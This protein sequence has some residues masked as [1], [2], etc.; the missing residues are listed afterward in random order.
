MASALEH[1]LA[2]LLLPDS[3]AIHTA[4]AAFYELAKQPGMHGCVPEL[5][6]IMQTNPQTEVR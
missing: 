3:H 6:R 5:V 4:T 1:I 2:Q